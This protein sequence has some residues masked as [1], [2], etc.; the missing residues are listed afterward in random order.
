MTVV[1]ISRSWRVEHGYSGRGGVVVV[2]QG[3]AQSWVDTLRNPEHWQPD[4][5]AV[6][7]QGRS[8]TTI[9]GGE[10]DGALMW[11]PNEP[12]EE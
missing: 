1:E 5:V 8:W 7:E 2:F 3:K 10:R 11:L 12:I 4:C 9:G 6:D